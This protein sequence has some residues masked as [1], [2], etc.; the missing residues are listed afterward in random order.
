VQ[1]LVLEAEKFGVFVGIEPV[2]THTI[3][4]PEK[5]KRLLD[6]IN[7]NNLQVVFDPVNLITIDNYKNQ[8]Q[9]ISKSLEL[10]GDK[11]VVVHCKDFVAEKDA[12]RTVTAGKGQLNYKL[13]AAFLKEDKPFIN[14]LLEETDE[15]F[16]EGSMKF[17][18]EI[19]I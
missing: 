9:I 11:I 8:D 6:A 10:F 12:L 13:L 16:M 18:R 7:S 1:K 15:P 19:G 17:L 2:A 3:N 5:M 14:C 4:S